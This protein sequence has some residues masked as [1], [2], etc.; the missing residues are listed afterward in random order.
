MTADDSWPPRFEPPAPKV[1]N[2]WAQWSV[3]FALVALVFGSVV[4][5]V[6]INAIHVRYGAGGTLQLAPVPSGPVWLQGKFLS[7]WWEVAAL[8]LIAFAVAAG[9]RSLTLIDRGAEYGVGST[10]GGFLV[11]SVALMA[12][13]AIL[14]GFLGAIASLVVYGK[15]AGARRAWT[16]GA[17][18]VAYATLAILVFLFLAYWFIT[19][20]FSGWSEG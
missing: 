1:D 16:T 3:I 17:A 7:S 5:I 2:T 19:W 13:N 9:I 10:V 6:E 8:V 15:H 20:A 12:G 4:A 18:I 14:L 11:S